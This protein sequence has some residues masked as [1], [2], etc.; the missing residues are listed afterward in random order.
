MTS[1]I[2]RS[3]LAIFSSKVAV[4][5]LTIVTTP[6]LVRLLGSDGYGDYS[7]LLSIF[8]LLIVFVYAGAFNG[9]RKYV[10]EDAANDTWAG[11]VFSF[12]FR[13][14]ALS[15]IIV[16]GLLLFSP[17]LDS[18]TL[19]GP[20]FELYFS[21]LALI[22]PMKALFRISR[23]GL[24]GFGLEV[25][26]EPLRIVDKLL[27]ASFVA[28]LFVF[29]GDVAA[30]LAG[31]AVAIGV[32]AVLAL[33]ILGR[34][35]DLTKIVRR[36]TN[37][38]PRRDLLTYSISTTGLAILLISLYHVDI[39]FLRLMTNNTE[40][41]YYRAALVVAEF[42]W[43]VPIAIQITLLHSTS[44]LW[45]EERYDRLTAI[46]SKTVRYTLLIT[47]LLV[48]GIAGLAEPFLTIYFGSEF[49]AAVDP[50]ILLLPGVLGFAVA[51]PV[52]AISQGQD[53][54]RILITATA[55]S[56]VSNVLLNV[57]LIPRFG[58]N[59]AA[60][61]TSISYGSM[62]FLHVW[63]ARQLGY[64]PIADVRSGRIA[65]TTGLTCFPIFALERVFA[66]DLL[67]LTV[68]PPIGALTFATFA[69]LTGAVTTTEVSSHLSSSPIPTDRLARWL[70]NRLVDLVTE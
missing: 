28:V 20:E 38:I 3:F 33:A 52:F 69:I 66:S 24:M 62:F 31:R 10:A 70:P 50:L 40:T 67:T 1:Q 41:G 8:Q 43:F 51:R 32:A 11:D 19:L 35:I 16:S 14:V 12:Y 21:L 27:F 37:S 36:T 68:I 61:A 46:G 59:G 39:V 65:V 64:D 54:L 44:P 57:L 6:L 60:I 30:V 63:S 55:V 2:I 5:G 13:I 42:L 7:F 58:M 26:S 4:L 48:V 34:R 25:Y 47:L 49:S 15:A 23:S 56:A 53:N 29:G 9:I 17:L 45:A 22:I 18:L